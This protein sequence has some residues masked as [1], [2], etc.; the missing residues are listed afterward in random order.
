MVRTL[1]MLL[2]FVLLFLVVMVFS[3]SNPGTVELDLAFGKYEV[4]TSIAFIV[5]AVGG[6]LWGMLTMLGWVVGLWNE[7]RRLRKQIRVANTELNNLRAL[8]MHDA[9]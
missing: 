8:P 5:A 1:L 9:N 4:E 7:R 2:A 3:L 6:W